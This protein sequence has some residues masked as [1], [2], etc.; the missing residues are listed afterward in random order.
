MTG[1]CG[2]VKVLWN[3]T[4]GPNCAPLLQ[5]LF[6]V[7]VDVSCNAVYLLVADGLDSTKA[8]NI[9][10]ESDSRQDLHALVSRPEWTAGV[11]VQ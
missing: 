7:D 3:G 10:R 1:C 2:V 9:S 4:V 6:H 8:R 11:F 5:C